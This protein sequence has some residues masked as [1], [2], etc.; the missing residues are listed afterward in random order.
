MYCYS[1]TPILTVLELPFRKVNFHNKIFSHFDLCTERR[2]GGNDSSASCISMFRVGI[3]FPERAVWCDV[4]NI[5]CHYGM[6][7]IINCKSQEDQER[8][9]LNVTE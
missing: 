6:V 4:T 8:I 2:G 9:I 1:N 5:S 3:W 7:V